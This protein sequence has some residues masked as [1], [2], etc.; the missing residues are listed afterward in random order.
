MESTLSKELANYSI[1]IRLYDNM[2]DLQEIVI[3][4]KNK[5][6]SND[7]IRNVIHEIRALRRR[8]HYYKAL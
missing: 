4:R 2:V 1:S 3:L 8:L 7:Y 5:K 6:L